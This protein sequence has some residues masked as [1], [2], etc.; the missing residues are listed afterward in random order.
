MRELKPT[1]TSTTKTQAIFFM[2]VSRK[3]SEALIFMPP[4]SSKEA[5]QLYISL[6]ALDNN[7]PAVLSASCLI[8]PL[9]KRANKAPLHRNPSWRL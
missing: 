3:E 7:V 5:T 2:R 9:G 4:Q 1:K 8:I 6:P